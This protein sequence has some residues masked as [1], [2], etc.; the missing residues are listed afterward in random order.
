M[1]VRTR[2]EDGAVVPG[3][4]AAEASGASVRGSSPVEE[5]GPAAVQRPPAEVR[6][7]DELAAL[8]ARTAIRG[9]RAG[10]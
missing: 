10:S 1:S 3:D 5:G 8:R 2:E 7:A 6:Y 9:H 4:G